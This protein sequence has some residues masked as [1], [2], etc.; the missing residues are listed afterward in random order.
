MS[1]ETNGYARE[2][3]A[4][5]DTVSPLPIDWPERIDRTIPEDVPMIT[6]VDMRPSILVP[7]KPRGRLER[8]VI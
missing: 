3:S 2:I 6:G 4:A 1:S 5:M 7:G 8:M